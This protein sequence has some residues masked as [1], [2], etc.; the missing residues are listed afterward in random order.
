LFDLPCREISKLDLKSRI[1]TRNEARLKCS[2][3]RYLYANIDSAVGR[4]LMTSP[5]NAINQALKLC[6]GDAKLGD[7]FAQ[8]CVAEL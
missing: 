4:V 7:E 2:L 5:R 8:L 1:S 6:L 3:W